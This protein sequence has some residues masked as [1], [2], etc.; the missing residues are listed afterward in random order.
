M[1]FL[2]IERNA[3]AVLMGVNVIKSVPLVFSAQV[4]KKTVWFICIK[5]D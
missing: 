5:Y 1:G 2:E 3:K 4:L